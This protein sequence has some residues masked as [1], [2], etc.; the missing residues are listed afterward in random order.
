MGCGRGFGG[1][2]LK[3][4]A[5]QDI[6]SILTRG[7]TRAGVAAAH[8]VTAEQLR[9][10]VQL[11]EDGARVVRSEMSRWA[12]GE[13]CPVKIAFVMPWSSELRNFRKVNG[14]PC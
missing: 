6:L 5:H 2:V 4:A 1:S 9:R 3:D 7:A 13:L 10:K 11:A 12:S 14:C 8:E